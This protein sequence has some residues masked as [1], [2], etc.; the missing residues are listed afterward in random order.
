MNFQTYWTKA[1]KAQSKLTALA[2]KT[3]ALIS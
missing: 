1:E 3:T 2:E